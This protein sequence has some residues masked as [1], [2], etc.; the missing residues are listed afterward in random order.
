MFKKENK[1]T[2]LEIIKGDSPAQGKEGTDNQESAT[3]HFLD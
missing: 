2:L 3:N 1:L